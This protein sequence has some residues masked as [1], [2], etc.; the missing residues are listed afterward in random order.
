[1][2]YRRSSRTARSRSYGRGSRRSYGRRSSS[3]RRAFRPTKEI[4][5][6]VEHAAPVTGAVPAVVPNASQQMASKRSMF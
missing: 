2:A 1:M 6:V 4:R 3:G 5:I